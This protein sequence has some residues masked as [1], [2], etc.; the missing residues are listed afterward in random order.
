MNVELV[1]VETLRSAE[2][3]ERDGDLH[4]AAR[5]LLLGKGEGTENC[6]PMLN[7]ILKKLTDDP[8]RCLD[9]PREHADAKA[10]KKGYRLAALKYHP[11]KNS[12]KTSVLFAAVQ[13][14]YAL[15]SDDAKRKAYDARS[16]RRQEQTDRLRKKKTQK[17][18]P[19]TNS[20]HVPP[21]NAADAKQRDFN[22]KFYNEYRHAAMNRSRPPPPPGPAPKQPASEK[23]PSKPVGLRMACKSHDTVTLEWRPGGAAEKTT[24]ASKAYE[25]QWRLRCESGRPKTWETSQQL[26]LRTTCRKRNLRPASCYEFRVRAASISGWS[27]HSDPLMVVTTAAPSDDQ[28]RP[29]SATTTNAKKVDFFPAVPGA[30]AKKTH[31]GPWHCVV[32]KRSNASIVD[33]CSICGTRKDYDWQSK[34]PA[35]ATTTKQSKYDPRGTDAEPAATTTDYTTTKNHDSDSDDDCGKTWTF[36]ENDV[37][38]GKRGLD[39]D[40]ID[41]WM[42]DPDPLKPA[43]QQATTS[44]WLNPGV[45][46]LHNVREEPIKGSTVVGHLIAD[47]EI[48]L[49]AETG[50]WIKCKYHKPYGGGGIL[51]NGGVGWCLRYDD[52]HQYIVQDSYAYPARRHSDDSGADDEVIYELRDEDNRVYYFNSYTGVSMWD[53]PDWVDEID[54]NSGAVYYTHSKTGETQWERPFDF[55]PIIREE[56][57]STAHARFVKD[58]LSPKRSFQIPHN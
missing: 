53:A 49:I 12:N 41:Q 29:A 50:N 58:I 30:T 2:K 51:P 33:K 15:L 24:A 47:T 5:C 57:Y 34:A 39:D 7:K 8:Y 23:P 13:S 55:V 9:V 6:A 35:A 46:S 19:T 25:L 21:T 43:Q 26:I 1:P 17:Q 36:S 37:P 4:G 11:D 42:D 22:R 38:T 27:P 52:E 16:E 3:L 44:C 14:A 10:I 48:V 31:G 56:I 45:T 40:D 32:C 18:V 20:F 54:D 28:Q